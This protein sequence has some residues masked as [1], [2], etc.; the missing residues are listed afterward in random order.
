MSK[1]VKL[2]VGDKAKLIE[3][4]FTDGKGVGEVVEI[5]D[6]DQRLMRFLTGEEA[7]G[8]IMPYLYHEDWLKR[9]D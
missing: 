1:R 4:P 7:R 6:T 9:I 8:V 5:L 2:K 3:S